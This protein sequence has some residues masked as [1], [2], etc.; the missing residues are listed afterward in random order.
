MYITNSRCRG[1]SRALFGP[2]DGRPIFDPASRPQLSLALLTSV[3]SDIHDFRRALAAHEEF[4]AYALSNPE[5]VSVRKRFHL[6]LLG[7]YIGV[8]FGMQH[9]PKGMT[10]YTMRLLQ[11]SGVQSMTLTYGKGVSDGLSDYRRR[12]IAWM[13]ASGMILDVSGTSHRITHDALEFIQREG[14]PMHLM[15]SQSENLPDEIFKEILSQGGYIGISPYEKEGPINVFAHAVK[16]GGVD[17]VGIGS[18]HHSVNFNVLEKVLL[19]K[20]SPSAVEGFLGLNF[21]DFLIRSL[22]RAI[23]EPTESNKHL[24]TI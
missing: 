19:R 14:L 21:R 1:D 11:K 4:V 9:A 6:E 8:L 23:G 10:Q 18:G 7:G 12:L 17:N 20:F 15:A 2:R 13:W 5:L 3:P 22:P 24:A 16:L